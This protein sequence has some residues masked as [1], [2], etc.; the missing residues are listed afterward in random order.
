MLII[1]PN[2]VILLTAAVLYGQL[3]SKVHTPKVTAMPV[4]AAFA[5]NRPASCCQQAAPL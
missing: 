4:N 1:Q 3:C 5:Q 2:R